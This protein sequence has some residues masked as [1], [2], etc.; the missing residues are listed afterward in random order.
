MALTKDQV[1]AEAMALDP[2]DREE[3]ADD[4]F[5]SVDTGPLTPE[6]REELHLRAA[7]IDRGEM[8]LIPVDEALR[9]LRGRA[10][11]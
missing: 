7:A 8:A 9:R 3:L 1:R 2:K 10:R 6:Q 11:Q 5:Q 4:L